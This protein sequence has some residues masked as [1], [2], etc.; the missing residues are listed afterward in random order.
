M[1]YLSVVSESVDKWKGEGDTSTGWGTY[2]HIP[3][4]AQ[5]NNHQV[6]YFVSICLIFIFIKVFA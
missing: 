2:P 3:D 5:M 6:S 4:E 1:S